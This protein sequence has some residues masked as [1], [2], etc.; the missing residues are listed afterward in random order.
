MSTVTLWGPR[1]VFARRA[2]SDFDTTFD[3]LV[4]RAFGTTTTSANAF[5]PAT[6]IARDG[7][8]AVLRVELP[9]LDAGNDVSVEVDGQQLVIKGERRA[10][11]KPS[12]RATS[13]RAAGVGR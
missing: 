1:P 8:D 9:G 13:L 6:E 10:W 5:V 12:S 2:F 4:R 3:T 11:R 7:D